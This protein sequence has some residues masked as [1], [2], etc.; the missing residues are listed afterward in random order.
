MN[1][2]FLTVATDITNFCNL[3][4]RVCYFNLD[5][6]VTK[7]RVS[8]KQFAAMF[9]PF[10]DR[11][12]TIGL[13]CAYEPLLAHYNDL[14]KILD[15]IKENEIP[16]SF[17]I[18]NVTCLDEKTAKLLVNSSLTCLQVSFNSHIKEIYQ[19]SHV[20]AKFEKVVEKIRFFSDYKKKIN[21]KLPLLQFNCILGRSN[22]EDM[23]EYLDFISE[24]G[25]DAID[26][27]H[28]VVYD[29]SGLEMESLHLHKEIANRYFDLIRKKT[30]ELGLHISAMPDNFCIGKPTDVVANSDDDKQSSKPC[31][32][33]E[34]KEERSVPDQVDE[35][36]P[37]ED[38]VEAAGH[39]EKESIPANP[40][41][42]NE[43]DQNITISSP[44]QNSKKAQPDFVSSHESQACSVRCTLPLEFMS[45]LPNGDVRPCTFWYGEA[46]IGN[47]TE[48][49]FDTLW[50]SEAYVKLRD[51]VSKGV[52]TRK[53]CRSCPTVG[54]G[55]VDDEQ[56]FSSKKI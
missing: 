34:V 11:I 1:R 24:L 9:G 22:I 41:S 2:R 54:G 21:T 3:K 7:E 35:R 8:H 44:I 33:N 51:D 18:T 25:A 5:D 48:T 52:F 16:E 49:D 30:S 14:S 17:L 13:S 20:G 19:A 15:F 32:V 12:K 53:C 45:V 46:P 31:G 50:N 6:K 42:K 55:S 23:L 28:L 47:L 4:C 36:K 39:I 40:P 29:G 38:S 56:S 43:P 37:I 10:S 26:L 27:R